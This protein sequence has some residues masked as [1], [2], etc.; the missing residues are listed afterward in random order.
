[1]GIAKRTESDAW[2]HPYTFDSEASPPELLTT[3]VSA[4]CLCF[5]VPTVNQTGLVLQEI[6]RVAIND[7]VSYF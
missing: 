7:L 3:L 1:V 4:G 5:G 6:A 2:I